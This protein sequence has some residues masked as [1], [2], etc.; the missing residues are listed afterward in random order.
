MLS[1]MRQ[2]EPALSRSACFSSFYLRSVSSLSKSLPVYLSSLFRLDRFNVHLSIA[3]S[4]LLWAS[5]Y[6]YILLPKRLATHLIQ[7]CLF[8]QDGAEQAGIF[9]PEDLPRTF[10]SACPG[11]S[12]HDQHGARLVCLQACRPAVAYF[13]WRSM[14]LGL[15]ST[16]KNSATSLTSSINLSFGA[17]SAMIKTR[18]RVLAD[19]QSRC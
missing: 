12:F 1:T 10:E 18:R 16:N 5:S 13:C 9:L 7:V 4:N 17:M 3:S 11:L 14:L 8:G 19:A 15:V 2:D 6:P